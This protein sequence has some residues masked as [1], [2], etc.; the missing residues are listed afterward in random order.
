MRNLISGVTSWDRLEHLIFFFFISVCIYVHF[1]MH[2]T[3]TKR[4]HLSTP[5]LWRAC[6]PHLRLAATLFSVV[7]SVT[8]LT[9]S[10]PA[11][12]KRHGHTMHGHML[13][14]INHIHVH[15]FIHMHN[16]IMWLLPTAFLEA[17]L[18]RPRKFQGREWWPCPVGSLD[19]SFHR[20][21]GAMPGPNMRRSWTNKSTK[22]EK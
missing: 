12:V 6:S 3:I 11:H 4:E 15:K 1:I 9:M 7:G 19:S 17:S 16:N 21:V 20:D 13:I 14:N 22:M 2:R 8:A 18:K 10:S 5:H